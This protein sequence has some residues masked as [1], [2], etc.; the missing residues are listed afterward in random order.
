[1]ADVDDALIKNQAR[2]PIARCR[3]RQCSGRGSCL[4]MLHRPAGAD[5]SGRQRPMDR[6]AH[7]IEG[8][9][10]VLCRRDRHSAGLRFLA[11]LWTSATVL[12]RGMF[13]AALGPADKGGTLGG[14]RTNPGGLD[15]RLLGTA[16]LLRRLR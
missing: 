7:G 12:W 8:L 13:G 16:F 10:A 9:P 1:M 2:S 4:I 6:E 15:H 5:F 11:C 3:G 14:K